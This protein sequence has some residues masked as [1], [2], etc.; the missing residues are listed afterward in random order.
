LA[1]KD[2]LEKIN[3]EKGETIQKNLTKFTQFWDELGSFGVILPKYYLVSPT[4]L[5]L[6]KS[7]HG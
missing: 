4:L 5:G 3:M 1:L 6:P 7:W 2:K